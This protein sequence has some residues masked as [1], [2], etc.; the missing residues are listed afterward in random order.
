MAP[1]REGCSTPR[2]QCVYPVY[3]NPLPKFASITPRLGT[4][5]LF[6]DDKCCRNAAL[7]GETQFQKAEK[8]TTGA[9]QKGSGAPHPP[10][11]FPALIA[12]LSSFVGSATLF[13]LGILFL[14]HLK[15]TLP[16]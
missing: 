11:N 15:N 8:S 13:D 12:H 14:Q 4:P 2:G 10:A 7:C 1:I 16:V 6:V 5:L 9:M 3:E